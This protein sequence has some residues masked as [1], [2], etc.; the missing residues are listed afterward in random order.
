MSGSV[1]TALRMTNPG[2]GRRGCADQRPSDKMTH[3][4]TQGEQGIACSE[5]RCSKQ[6]RIASPGLR[7]DLGLLSGRINNPGS[8]V[9]MFFLNFYPL[10]LF[11]LLMRDKPALC[12]QTGSQR[13]QTNPLGDFWICF[14]PAPVPDS[15]E[16]P[17]LAT[18]PCVRASLQTFLCT[19]HLP[20]L[21]RRASSSYQLTI[22]S[23]SIPRNGNYPAGGSDSWEVTVPPLPHSAHQ[24]SPLTLAR[25]ADSLHF[26]GLER[27]CKVR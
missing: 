3:A 9:G 4:G 19:G 10:Y 16:D 14:E 20:P 15:S 26:S 11:P 1:Y 5:Q 21:G 25:R 18:F 13:N 23:P 12:H 7:G 27:Q 6:T 22:H 17:S 24:P 2:P 8:E